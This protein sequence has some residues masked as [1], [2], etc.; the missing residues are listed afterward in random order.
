MAEV[1]AVI[2]AIGGGRTKTPVNDG[3]PEAG[4]TGLEPATSGVTGRR[5][6]QLSYAP[7]GGFTVSQA[8]LGSAGRGGGGGRPQLSTP[9]RVCA[10]ESIS[11]GRAQPGRGHVVGISD[12]DPSGSPSYFFNGPRGGARRVRTG[13]LGPMDAERS[14]AQKAPVLSVRQHVE[15]IMRVALVALGRIAL[16]IGQD[17]PSR[18]LA[19]VADG[20]R[21]ELHIEL[22]R[23]LAALDALADVPLD[24]L[25]HL[26]PA[27]LH[28][29]TDDRG[30]PLEREQ[31]QTPG[32]GPG[33]DGL[34]EPRHAAGQKRA[35]G[36]AVLNLG[37]HVRK[38]LERDPLLALDHG[39]EK[40]VQVGEVV[41]DPRPRN[42]SGAGNRLDRDARVAPVQDHLEGGVD[43]VFASLLG[44]HPRRVRAPTSA[45]AGHG[46]CSH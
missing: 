3:N 30:C 12:G 34:E 42:T 44:R 22:A 16:G 25:E 27:P 6:N 35:G 36:L 9:P 13:N 18:L 39:V 31:D 26:R 29:L 4:A 5:S 14:E 8:T 41:V 11:G 10:F 17:H 28:V 2:S 15:E 40:P 38:L 7:G 43:Q 46:T 37:D 1:P 19:E 32:G 20:T 24:P 45:W 21:G 23:K 33:R